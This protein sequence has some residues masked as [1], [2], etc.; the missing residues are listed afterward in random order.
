LAEIA[1]KHC[2][3]GIRECDVNRGIF[4]IRSPITFD[5]GVIQ[6]TSPAA[7]GLINTISA[8]LGT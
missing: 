6:S 1:A 7:R 2:Y 8:F 3:D 5:E 4:D